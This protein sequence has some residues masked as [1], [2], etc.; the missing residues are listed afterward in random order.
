MAV[1]TSTAIIGAAVIGAGGA[2]AAHEQQERAAERA[3]NRQERANA[4]QQARASVDRAR[5]RRRAIA[6]SRIIQARNEAMQS[7]DVQQS[8][9]LSGISSAMTS[10]LGG[11][12]AAQRGRAGT[13]QR[14]LDLRQSASNI[15]NEGR[16]DASLT[17]G[18]T[19]VFTQGINS[20]A[21]FGAFE[22]G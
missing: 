15:L 21:N 1:A 4:T 18:L 14:T 20:A 3:E 5:S 7:E 17:Q 10:G 16:R 8:S 13:A 19:G 2:F 22:Q 12:I 6:Q 11:N 9:A